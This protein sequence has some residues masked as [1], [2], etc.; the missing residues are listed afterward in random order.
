MAEQEIMHLDWRSLP[1]V[2]KIQQEIVGALFDVDKDGFWMKETVNT[3]VKGVISLRSIQVGGGVI[4]H[5][6]ARTRHLTKK[7][8]DRFELY[9]ANL[10]LLVEFLLKQL[11]NHTHVKKRFSEYANSLLMS[12]SQ[13]WTMV[14][15]LALTRGLHPSSLGI[16]AESNGLLY[17]GSSVRINLR[18]ADNLF[19]LAEYKAELQRDHP[20][21]SQILFTMDRRDVNRTYRVY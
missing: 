13:L 14:M 7:P 19:N 15:D 2:S 4:L 12:Q 5:Y 9:F 10:Y 8:G 11:S 18:V 6:V 16:E 1:K 21:I 20:G 17:S 3:R